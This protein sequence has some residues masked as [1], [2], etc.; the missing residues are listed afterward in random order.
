MSTSG[1]VYLLTNRAFPGYVKIGYTRAS[2]FDRAEELYTTGVPEPFTVYRA[3]YVF[4]AAS[5]EQAIHMVLAPR[6]SAQGA[7]EF[8][9]VTVDEAI[10]AITRVVMQDLVPEIYDGSGGDLEF[11][12]EVI[13]SNAALEAEHAKL[14]DR[15]A[16][17]ECS[18]AALKA[19]VQS[20]RGTLASY[21]EANE[22][23]RLVG[24]L[25]AERDRYRDRYRT[26]VTAVLEWA[27]EYE[28]YML[29]LGGRFAR[30]AEE[31]AKDRP[32][33]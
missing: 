13:K 3:W 29:S 21:E 9:A 31:H 6:R 19:Q 15:C 20:L 28:R 18:E 26:S 25:I 1:F 24:A 8:F 5:A 27:H 33:V 32:R 16:A 30:F 7:R 12:N 23:I 11:F 10:G 2:P 22:K 4:D 14:A 17:L